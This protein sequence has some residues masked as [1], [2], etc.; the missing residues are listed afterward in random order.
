M[1]TNRLKN[2]VI[3]GGGT[4]GWITAA[5]LSHALGS[6]LKITLVE[7]DQIPTVGVGEATIPPMQRLHAILG[8]S[9]KEFMAATNATF[10]LGICF[11][12]WKN[13]GDSYIHSFG[14]AGA[15]SWACHF[16]NFWM[17][18]HQRGF[19]AE[20]G[21][22]I[23]EHAAARLN[24]F[25]VMPNSKINYAYHLDAGL[26]AKM[27]RDYSEKLGVQRCEGTIQKV[28]L[29]ESDGFIESLALTD[30]RML[31]GDLFIDCTG[32][33]A[34]LIGDALKTEYKDWSH[35]LPCNRALAVQ[36][37]KVDDPIPYTR[38]I[39]H[40]SGWQ[41]RIPLQHRVG[42]GM[43]YS[44]DFQSEE[45]ARQQLLA[46]LTGEP[47]MQPKP[48]KF[49][50]GTRAQHWNK[51][52]VAIGLSSGFLEPLESTSIHLIQSAATY[53][54]KY[55]PVS[56]VKAVDVAD[57]NKQIAKEVDYIRDFIIL[58]YK[59]TERNDSEFWQY[60][61]NM[62]VPD[63]LSSRIELFRETGRIFKQERELFS[64]ESWI[65][66]MLGQGLM[67]NAYH[68][69]ADEMSDQQLK[70]FLKETRAAVEK[71]LLSLPLHK[72][73]IQYYCPSK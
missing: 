17:A 40:E 47:L 16:F 20:Y 55:F 67:P 42:N 35:W 72:D 62:D 9:E 15:D 49:T 25:A 6:S 33:R 36:T 61:K 4:S 63:S 56:E 31:H 59:V 51:N 38:S 2:V 69:I 19:S 24:K 26:Y 27:L 70:N 21:D 58:H 14:F 18:G 3:A 1:N 50:T 60:C 43:V 8:I 30:G 28:N 22:Y 11:E 29:R 57:F 37:Q 54:I 39:A 44:S 32:F 48:I 68:P 45:S 34:L 73:F 52:C 7:S 66:V 53:L 71:D 5:L 64:E 10:K 13:K 46:N 41:W 23:T 12:N 65:Q